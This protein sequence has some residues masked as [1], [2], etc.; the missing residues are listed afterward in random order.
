L[1]CFAPVWECTFQNY[2]FF[3]HFLNFWLQLPF[4]LCIKNLCVISRSFNLVF[5]FPFL[6]CTKNLNKMACMSQKNYC[7]VTLSNMQ[8]CVTFLKA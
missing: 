6:T 7:M 1:N 8:C 2:Y 3:F 4:F 5:Y